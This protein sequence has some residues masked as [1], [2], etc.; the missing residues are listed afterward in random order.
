[1]RNKNAILGALLAL[2]GAGTPA[3]TVWRCGAGYSPQPCEGGTAVAAPHT[4]TPAE[5]RQ[6]AAAAQVDAK[7]AEALEKARLAQEKNAPK[8]IVIAPVE[9][10]AKPAEKGRK[11]AKTGKPEEFTAVAPGKPRDRQKKR[12]D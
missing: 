7:R 9:P 12:K 3:Q 6:A 2:A 4:P 5:A 11:A 8:A 10:A 1:V